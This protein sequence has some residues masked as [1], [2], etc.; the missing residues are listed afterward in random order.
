MLRARMRIGSKSIPEPAV[1][2]RLAKGEIYRQL[3]DS[4][5]FFQ[6]FCSNV[7]AWGAPVVQ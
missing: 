3:T 2:F 1:V 6:F 5:V 7:R 4:A